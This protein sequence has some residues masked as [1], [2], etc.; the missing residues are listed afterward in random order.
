MEKLR[1]RKCFAA[2]ELRAASS[3]KFARLEVKVKKV[4]RSR[5]IPTASSAHPPASPQQKSAA[6][7]CT[8]SPHPSTLPQ[9]ISVAPRS[10]RFPR[11]RPRVATIQQLSVKQTAPSKDTP[12][13]LQDDFAL[14]VATMILAMLLSLVFIAAIM[15]L[16]MGIF[17]FQGIP[18]LVTI[19][20]AMYLFLQGV[21]EIELR[22]LRIDDDGW[23]IVLEKSGSDSE[24][25]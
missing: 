24:G 16:P 7:P 13:R 19:V 8:S 22:G 18:L 15:L 5:R 2:S 4:F 10:A 23:H 14:R 9:Q 21:E 25:S 6:P 3:A 17:V 11:K 12:D 1:S 20:V